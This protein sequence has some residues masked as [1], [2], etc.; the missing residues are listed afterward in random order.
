M[1]YLN[2]RI[3]APTW[4][5]IR[6][7]RRLQRMALKNKRPLTAFERRLILRERRLPHAP[8]VMSGGEAAWFLVV[9]AR[10]VYAAIRDGLLPAERESLGDDRFRWR[11]LGSDVQRLAEILS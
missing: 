3:A 10:V 1:S 8:V 6:E 4:S 11:V 5:S 7:D 2:P 9:D